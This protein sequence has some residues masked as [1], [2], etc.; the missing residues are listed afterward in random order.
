MKLKLFLVFSL[1]IST[2]SINAQ[3]DKAF[4]SLNL[5]ADIDI[6]STSDLTYR[7]INVEVSN[8]GTEDINVH[9]PPG[10]FFVNLDSNEQNLVVLFYDVLEVKAGQKE[11]ALIGTACANPNRK[12]P[13]KGRTTWIY[14]YDETK[15]GF[16]LITDL[17][18]N[19]YTLKPIALS[20]KGQSLNWATNDMGELYI[21][22]YMLKYITKNYG[23]E[24]F[25]VVKGLVS[26]TE[27]E[28]EKIFGNYINSFYDEKK[29][30][31]KLNEAGDV[32]YNE[33]LRSTIK[34][35]LNSLT[36]KLVENPAIH[37]SLK[38]DEN[39]III[40][41]ECIFFDIPNFATC[42]FLISFQT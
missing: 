39:S 32:S 35:Y 4:Y 41:V 34:L 7:H 9:F 16:Y 26:D 6:I 18:F 29:Q 36:G 20:N 21:D 17:V 19:S 23:L 25:K 15:H 11:S 37:F 42:H 33:A 30:Q 1:F 14:D 13:K 12:P 40:H 38:F 31:D 5:D 24:S 27:I 3:T 10:G 22:S 8:F 2:F 28:G